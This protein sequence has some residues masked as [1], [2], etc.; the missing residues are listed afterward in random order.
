M[1]ST[2]DNIVKRIIKRLEELPTNKWFD[3]PKGELVEDKRDY[4]T[5]IGKYWIHLYPNKYD[6][7]EMEITIK[8]SNTEIMSTRNILTE[9]LYQYVLKEQEDNDQRL[10]LQKL[11]KLLNKIKIKN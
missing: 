10:E 8:D 1:T 3:G 5:Y 4:W 6:L 11:E 2:T 7:A 9:H